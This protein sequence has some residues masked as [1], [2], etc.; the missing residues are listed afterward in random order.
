MYDFILF[1]PFDRARALGVYKIAK[2]L[3]DQGRSVKVID[4]LQSF[5]R[6]ST[7]LLLWLREHVHENT[8]FGFS[9]TFMGFAINNGSKADSKINKKDVR[10]STRD[11][12]SR[13]KYKNP[14]KLLISD[15]F[16]NFIYDLKLDF[17]NSKIVIGGR[18][19]QKSN[20][21][22]ISIVLRHS[23]CSGVRCII[24]EHGS[25]LV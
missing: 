16:Q 5:V 24:L 10:N 14:S 23:R 13:E 12:R 1:T 2:V 11:N 25:L 6:D 7:P 20:L 19:Q 4:F 9:G 17:P 18:G 21:V 15:D 3:R 8:I 22:P